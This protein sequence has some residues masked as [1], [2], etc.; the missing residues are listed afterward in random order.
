MLPVLVL[1]CLGAVCLAP[2]GVDL[3]HLGLRAD[4]DACGLGELGDGCCEV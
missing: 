2:W 4:F 3:G 1:D